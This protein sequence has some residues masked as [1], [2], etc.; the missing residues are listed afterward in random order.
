MLLEALGALGE[1]IE[2]DAEE[3]RYVARVCRA[4]LHAT[5][6]ATDG[7]GGLARLRIVTLGARVRAVFE[8][9]EERPRAREAM[10]WCGAPEG[11][12]ADWMV[13]KL[14]ELGVSALQPLQCARG[15]WNATPARLERWSRL[16]GAALKQSRQ[17]W[18]MR[19]LEPAGIEAVL[20]GATG[21]ASKWIA[22]PEG[23]RPG[24]EADLEHSI[25]VIG[26]SGGFDPAET[27]LFEASGFRAMS[28]ASSR[29]RTE[30]A[31]IAW[32]CWWGAAGS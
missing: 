8:H 19:I 6:S 17:A 7:R 27:R 16:A 14:A 12:R 2:L 5:L 3:S 23:P 25:G 29:L 26:P 22:D 30:T 24:R 31:A 32:A 10:L 21:R 15:T 9:L 11:T 28:L 20:A 18:R 4:R 13:E 1:T